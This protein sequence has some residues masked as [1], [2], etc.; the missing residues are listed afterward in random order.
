MSEEERRA[1]F[2]MA[3]QAISQQYGVEVR[4]SLQ[5]EQLGPVVQVRPVL[6]LVVIE[7]WSER[8]NGLE[9]SSQ[10]KGT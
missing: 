7:G 2:M 1:A 8:G 4:V 10:E 9:R 6:N 5:T 3:L